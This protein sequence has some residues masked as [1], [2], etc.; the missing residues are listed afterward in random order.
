MEGSSSRL[1]SLLL[2]AVREL[3]SSKVNIFFMAFGLVVGIAAMTSIYSLGRG[4]EATI[5]RV[6]E[7]L[8]FGS[9]SFLVL[10]GGGKFFGPAATRRDRFKMGD[11]EAIKRFDFVVDISPVQ[12]GL[13][14]VAS[15][16]NAVIT[17]VLGVFPV[18]S[19][20]DNWDVA[21]GR[22]ITQKDIRLK[23]K[24]CV[25]GQETAKRLFG[26]DALGKRLRVNGVSLEVVGVLEKKGVIG[27]YRLD[28]RVLV[29]FTTAKERIFNKDWIDAAKVVFKRGTD[30][31][32]AKLVVAR[33]LRR[34]HKLLPGEIDDFRIITPD[35]IVSFLTK[36]TR[37]ITA[38]LFVISLITL[39]VSGVIIMNIMFSVVE[40]KKKIIALRKAFGATEG[41]IA[42]HY[43]V[44]TGG[45][46]LIGG[47][48]GYL[49]GILIVAA[50]SALTPVDGY[51]S[52]LV[53]PPALLF[54]VVTGVLFGVAPARAA[55]KLP[56]AEL[57]R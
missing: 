56:P 45:V 57:L 39:V 5:V 37:T 44:I 25:V 36:A 18:Y 7:S 1:K 50:V 52:P 19:R 21:Q 24:V 12:I 23:S 3:F 33:L 26:G 38:L 31:K 55:S 42:L 16:T 28:D 40:E 2:E 54:S 11:I 8:N 34:R 41:D 35:Q 30:L 15:G 46:S 43:L 22:F 47:T 20:V 53:L 32:K 6:L 48:A 29:P 10:A 17:R 51:F 49:L 13:M 14:Q 9:N 4:A 27:T